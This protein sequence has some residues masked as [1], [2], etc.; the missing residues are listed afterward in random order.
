MKS[1]IC[2]KCGEMRFSKEA[3]CSKCGY[4][5][6]PKKNKVES[7]L[8]ESNAIEGVYDEDSFQQA[9][10]AWDFLS[11]EKEMTIGVVLKT[12]K[13]LMLHQKIQPDERGYFRKCEVQIGNRYGLN[14]VMVP[15][16]MHVWCQNAWLY[17]KNWKE[18]HVR[19]EEI[20]PFVDGNGR[21]GRM[22][23]NWERLKAGFGIMVIKELKKYEYYQ[24][25][26]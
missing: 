4:M 11:K 21:L 14:W 17:P 7:F 12:H 1:F 9:M 18:H 16:A 2:P 24:W 26:Q 23:M 20:H 15:E 25:F 13:I 3:I 8:R 10:Y 5:A 19:F 22:L 6:L